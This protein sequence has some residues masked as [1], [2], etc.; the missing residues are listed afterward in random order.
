MRTYSVYGTG[1]RV[2][3]L[4]A[5]PPDLAIVTQWISVFFLPIFPIRRLKCRYIGESEP[6]P[7]WEGG[8]VFEEIERLQLS[9]PSI[10][11]TYAAAVVCVV[12][13][14]GPLMLILWR[15]ANRAAMP[16]EAALAIASAVWPV[17]FVFWIDRRQ[18][19]SLESTWGRER[20]DAVRETRIAG[21]AHHRES[22]HASHYF[23]E[24]FYI[25]SL[26]VGLVPGVAIGRWFG[27]GWHLLQ[28]AGL[29]TAAS[30]IGLVALVDWCVMRCSKRLDR[31]QQGR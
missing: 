8:F 15:I 18:K 27:W 12:V 24:T 22:W 16:F 10:L 20:L 14:V 17:V 28:V 3:G 6:G 11:S 2:Y 30:A 7:N 19:Q 4:E 1:L 23:S 26:A 9:L 25:C 21:K 5:E 29:V 31:T 13:A